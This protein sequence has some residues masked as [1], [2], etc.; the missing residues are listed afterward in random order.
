MTLNETSHFE[1]TKLTHFAIIEQIIHKG[2]V[3]G[4][5]AINIRDN[6]D[7]QA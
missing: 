2:K 3:G 7:F 6:P 1:L 5:E 4:N